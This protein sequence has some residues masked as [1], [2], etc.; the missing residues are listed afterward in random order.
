MTGVQTCA[1]PISH[2][3]Q[4][5][6]GYFDITGLKAQLSRHFIATA[7]KAFI[8]NDK[9]VLKPSGLI[10]Y[11]DGAPVNVDI[12]ISCLYNK[13]F[14]LGVSYRTSKDIV[15]I[16]EFN[17]T[18]FMRVGY[19]YDISLSEIRNYSSGSHEIFIGFDFEVQK[20]KTISTRFL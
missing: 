6:I 4:Q 1:L 14:W 20:V 2:I 18:D 16:T 9:F 19:S 15:I 11:T 12:N 8:I 7:G 13:V 17:I 5:K 10:K 3:S